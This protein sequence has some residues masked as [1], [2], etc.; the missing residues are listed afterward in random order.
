MKFKHALLIDDNNTDNYIA[1]HIIT[2][3]NKADRI[4][5]KNSAIKALEYLNTINHANE[6]FIDII[7]LDINMPEMDGFDFLD[8]LIKFPEE[9]IA[10]TS[11][12]MLTSSDDPKDINRATQYSIVKKYLVKPLT[13]DILNELK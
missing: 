12:F 5:I 4:T 3:S 13:D 8:E 2:Q 7:F 11:V 1:K 9:I 10:K 6:E